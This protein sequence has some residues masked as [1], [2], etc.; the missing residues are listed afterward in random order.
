MSP[1][2]SQMTAP[3]VPRE[4]DEVVRRLLAV[5]DHLEAGTLHAVPGGPLEADLGELVKAVNP[6]SAWIHS[7]RDNEIPVPSCKR[8]YNTL[9]KTRP[10]YSAFWL[11]VQAHLESH[12]IPAKVFASM[13][14]KA[15]TWT[16]SPDRHHLNHN[17]I[18]DVDS[19]TKLVN[20]LSGV[21]RRNGVVPQPSPRRAR[22]VSRDRQEVHRKA[23]DASNA[24]AALCIASRPD[25]ADAF[26]LTYAVASPFLSKVNFP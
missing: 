11:V 22:K 9:S 15:L 20:R 23:I 7:V 4:L 8:D 10:A 5:R 13:Y 3:G 26:A 18:N 21:L 6:V 24:L 19:F 1:V 25:R 2:S 12:G 17:P 16:H 14:S